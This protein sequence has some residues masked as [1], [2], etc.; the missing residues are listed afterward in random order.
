MLGCSLLHEEQCY[1]GL[2]RLRIAKDMAHL[3]YQTRICQHCDEPGCLAACPSGAMGMDARG[4]VLL[5][6]ELCIRCGSCA[7]AC[8]YDAI[9]YNERE[10]RYLKCDLCAG[11]DGGPLC[12]ALCPMAALVA[13]RS[14]RDSEA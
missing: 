12:V 13:P 2:A 14:R 9:F 5:D 7:E 10:D 8:P 4:V 3:S 6:D 1:P 11:R